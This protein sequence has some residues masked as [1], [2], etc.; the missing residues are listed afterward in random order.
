MAKVV[1]AASNGKQF[2]QQ[3][4]AQG[5]EGLPDLVISDLAMPG[6]DGFQV[7]SWLYEN[8]PG[9]PIIVLSL[10]LQ[11]TDVVRLLKV[12][13]KGFLDKNCE[14]DALLDAIKAVARGEFYFSTIWGEENGAGNVPKINETTMAVIEKW[15]HLN[16]QERQFVMLACQDIE[17][18]EIVRQMNI[19][20][21]DLDVLKGRVFEH[22]GVSGRIGLVKLA[23]QHKII[24]I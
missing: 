5:P 12:G 6:M 7:A 22:F 17:Y 9:L 1:L 18:R 3:I 2:I 20:T 13:V 8:L 11:L 4:T 10:R 21:G 14:S 24:G 23:V 16:R 15:N 19:R